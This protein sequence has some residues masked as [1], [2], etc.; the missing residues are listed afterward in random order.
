MTDKTKDIGIIF[1]SGAGLQGWIWNKV[2]QGLDI[3][4]VSATFSNL[5]NLDE[6]AN[7]A[8]AQV[9][10]LGTSRTVIVAHSIGGVVG[11]EL[12]KKLGDRLAGF[13]G[14]SAAIPEPGKSYLSVFPLPQRMLLRLVFKLAGTKPPE[15]A[16]RK[17]LCAD[18]D[19]QTATKIVKDF[20]PEPARL[21]T[22]HTSPKPIPNSPMLYIST[23]VDK[24][25]PESLQTKM[26][27]KLP[28]AERI[29]IRSGH[30]P[31]LSHPDKV[32]GHIKEFLAR[33]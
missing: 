10:E 17:G 2:A 32:V 13:V 5:N 16:I 3:P 31:M 7:S 25:L 6:Y 24:E 28:G 29:S 1:I 15:S 11:L 20:T 8:L 19:D 23:S 18:L 33:V 26:S 22:D 27:S 21:Y 14:V 4:S 9:N 30:L 12:A